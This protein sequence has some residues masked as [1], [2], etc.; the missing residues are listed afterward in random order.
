M[1]R[2]PPPGG[3]RPPM[4]MGGM[5]PMGMRPPHGEDMRARPPM[6]PP[7]MRPPPP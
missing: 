4:P 3:M 6:M 2:G 5:P 1:I 7:G